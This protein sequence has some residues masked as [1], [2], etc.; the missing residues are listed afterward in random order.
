M[1]KCRVV[2][3]PDDP[4]RLLLGRQVKLRMNRADD[5]VQRGKHAVIKIKGSVFQDVALD[6]LEQPNTAEFLVEL[7]DFLY[8]A[9]QSFFV[10]SSG[11]GQSLGVLRD[12][13]VVIAPF[14]GGLGHLFERVFAVTGLGVAMQIAA[15]I[16]A[17]DQLGKTVLFGGV[18]LATIF[19]HFRLRC[20][21][22][23]LACRP[24]LQ[25][26]RLLACHRGIRR[27]R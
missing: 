17:R 26:A 6:P 24:P 19:A 22:S 12:G 4:L 10:Q 27:T 21:P 9:S 3:R 13:Q 7:I 11:H 23:R 2:H 18:N 15:N 8:L 14:L 5:Y 16:V 25:S 20:T 1:L